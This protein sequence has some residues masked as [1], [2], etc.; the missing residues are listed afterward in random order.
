MKQQ[1]NFANMVVYLVDDTETDLALLKGLVS[2]LHPSLVIETFTNPVEALNT[3]SSYP[4]DLLVTDYRM[5]ELSGL[6]LI[7]KLH[8]LSGCRDIPAVITTIV[9]DVE[10]RYAALEN[11]ATDYLIKPYDHREI[12]ARCRNL[13]DLRYHQNIVNNRALWLQEK[14]AEATKPISQREYD[15]LVMISNLTEGSPSLNSYGQRVARYCEIVAGILGYERES[16]RDLK[17]A[18]TLA[19]IGLI[20]ENHDAPYTHCER[21]RGLLSIPDT[22]FF[23][24]CC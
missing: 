18:A 3:A 11:G 12:I 1:T 13:L 2:Q 4:P 10:L 19:N 24:A 9:D 22:P 8:E 15:L 14:V 16:I 17:H 20:Y 5:P 7:N 21:G 23:S 6:E